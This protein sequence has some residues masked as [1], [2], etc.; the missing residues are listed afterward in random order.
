MESSLCPWLCTPF[1]GDFKGKP[2]GTPGHPPKKMT[3]P[4]LGVPSLWVHFVEGKIH[5]FR[6]GGA[7]RQ[8]LLLPVL[9]VP[10]LGNNQIG[11]GKHFGTNH[12]VF[13]MLFSLFRFGSKEY[14]ICHG[15]CCLALLS[16][17]HLDSAHR[18]KSGKLV[19]ARTKEGELFG[20]CI[21][22]HVLLWMNFA[23]N[24]CFLMQL[25]DPRSSVKPTCFRMVLPICDYNDKKCW[26]VALAFSIST[27]HAGVIGCLHVCVYMCIAC[28]IYLKEWVCLLWRVPNDLGGF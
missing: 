24:R 6:C 23:R 11:F 10:V 14:H 18:T 25:K 15:V 26:C 7:L 28:V 2:K 8:L 12:L 1:L 27:W 9:L 16:F 13:D 3:R 5:R 19:Q 21:S 20:N 22:W 17:T 4:Y